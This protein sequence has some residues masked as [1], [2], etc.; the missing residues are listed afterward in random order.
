M[1]LPTLLKKTVFILSGNFFLSDAVRNTTY[2]WAWGHLRGLQ[3]GSSV[4]DIGSRDSLFPAFLAWKRYAVRVVERDARFTGRQIINGKRWG[5][6]MIVDNCDFLIAAVPHPCDAVCSLFSLQHAGN[7]DTP[8]YCRAARLLRPG[9]LL[10]SAAEYCH[11]GSRFHEG[12]DDG[13]MRIYG[14]EDIE[15]RIEAP[16]FSEGM[17]E[18]DRQYYAVG[19]HGKVTVVTTAPAKGTMVLLLFRKE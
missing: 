8:A 1:H 5:V 15:K 7:K 12:R 4:V 3:C 14:P 2:Q 13:A 9:G 10:L 6:R 18:F 17:V 19:E 11:K 16:L